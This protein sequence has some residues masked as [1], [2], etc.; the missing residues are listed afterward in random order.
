MDLLA[1]C[2]LYC[3][4]CTH[5]RAAMPEGRHL[6]EEA[7]R[8]GRTP[9]DY[10]CRGCRSDALY[11]HPGCAQCEIRACAEGRGLLHCGLCTDQ[12]CARLRAFQNNGRPHHAPVLEQLIA[13]ARKGADRWLRERERRWTCTCGTPYSWYETTC[14]HCAAPLPSYGPDPRARQEGEE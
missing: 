2:G 11:V 8:H 9:A 5:Y 3:G 14:P 1:V 13:C 6:L 4:A 12:P 10:T 7:A